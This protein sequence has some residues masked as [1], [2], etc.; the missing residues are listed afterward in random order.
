LFEIVDDVGG[1]FKPH[2]QA[3]ET[4]G[5]A[6]RFALGFGHISVRH[7]HGVCNEGFCSAK[8]LG[9]RAEFDGVHHRDAPFDAPFDFKRDN[10]AVQGFPALSGVKFASEGSLR[11]RT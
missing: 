3:D 8:V 11:E 5:D 6:S 2:T 7:A 10:P 1:I 9:E 4:V